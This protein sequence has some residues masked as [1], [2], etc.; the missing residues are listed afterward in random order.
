[1]PSPRVGHAVNP[2]VEVRW[3]HPRRHAVPQAART[4]HQKL[5]GCFREGVSLGLRQAD[6]KWIGSGLEAC[7]LRRWRWEGDE[8]L[9]GSRVI[10]PVHLILL[11]C[12]QAHR[13]ARRVLAH[14]PSRDLE[15][16]GRRA[17]AETDVLAPCPAMVAGTGPAAGPQIY[18]CRPRPTSGGPGCFA[19]RS[20]SGQ[21]RIASIAASHRLT[22][23]SG[24]LCACSSQSAA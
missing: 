4:P 12:K 11:S 7:V 23:C 19:A 9:L 20:N 2:F 24:I 14:S 22:H 16:H 18:R 1:V 15:R 17:R 5:V 10:H 6:G 8:K 13:P 3:R 21:H